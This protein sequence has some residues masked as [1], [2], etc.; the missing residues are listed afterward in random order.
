MVAAGIG[1]ICVLDKRTRFGRRGESK[2]KKRKKYAL[3]CLHD[4][5]AWSLATSHN[6]IQAGACMHAF[7]FDSSQLKMRARSGMACLPPT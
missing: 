2:G 1:S 7:R 4:L 3:K 6:R 5:F